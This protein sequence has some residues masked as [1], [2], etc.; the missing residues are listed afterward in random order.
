MGQVTSQV[1]VL[2][3]A[4][5][6]AWS[7]GRISQPFLDEETKVAVRQVGHSQVQPVCQRW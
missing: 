3:L 1:M 2:S 4:E 6:Q 7:G 5:R